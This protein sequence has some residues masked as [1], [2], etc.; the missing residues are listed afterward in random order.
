M[1]PIFNASVLSASL[2]LFFVMTLG[3][4][5]KP[6]SRLKAYQE[7][8]N[9]H[10][11]DRVMSF[12][13]ED[14]RFEVIGGHVKKGKENLRGWAEWDAAVNC[15]LTFTDLVVRGDTVTCKAIE[16]ND[17]YRLA[18]IEKVYYGSNT[19]IFRDELITK[20]KAELTEESARAIGE[21][22]QSITEWASQE[23][24]QQLAELMPEGK[25]VYSAE[26]AKGWLALLRERQEETKL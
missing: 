11:V 8:L 14:I 2:L 24:S 17:W 12:Y 13:A 6:A 18:G 20:I 4:A 3:C 1:R 22:F 9:S 10:D 15:H 21:A 25:I 19:I 23:R 16:Q 7:A 26:T 5:P